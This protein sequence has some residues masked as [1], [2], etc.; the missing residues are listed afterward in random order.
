MHL[1]YFLPDRPG[2]LVISIPNDYINKIQYHAMPKMWKK[3]MI[4]Q[5]YNYLNGPIHSMVRFFKIRIENLEKLISPGVLSRYSKKS[6]KCSKKRKAV[7][8][9]VD[10]DL[11]QKQKG[12]M[13]C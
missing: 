6:K 11:D 5:G 10:K 9:D 12:K 13:F 4:K 7:N 8:F 2:Q 1:L 3:K